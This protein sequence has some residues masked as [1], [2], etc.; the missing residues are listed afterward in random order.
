M[1]TVN[2]LE[3]FAITIPQLYTLP[4]ERENPYAKN[5][6]Y[7]YIFTLHFMISFREKV[8]THFSKQKFVIPIRKKDPA[9]KSGP[10]N[11]PTFPI[12]TCTS[13]DWEFWS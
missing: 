13:W 12:K 1:L 5:I 9:T 10:W 11:S 7:I 8:G 4:L 3:I 2:Y 6:R